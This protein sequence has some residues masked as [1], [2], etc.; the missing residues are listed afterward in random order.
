MPP[1]EPHPQPVR[2]VEGAVV[3]ATLSHLSNIVADMVRFQL[4]TDCRPG[5]LC[6]LRPIDIDRSKDV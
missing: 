5:E 3:D 4:L 6:I 2:P 1:E